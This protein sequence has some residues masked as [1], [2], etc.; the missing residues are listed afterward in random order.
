MERRKSFAEG[1]SKILV[2]HKLIKAEEAVSLQRLFE[3]SPKEYFDDFLLEEGIVDKEDLIKALQEYFKV[4]AVDVVGYFFQPFLVRKFPKDVL[5]RYA[6]IPMDV[7]E[8]MMSVVAS[9]PDDP[10]LLPLI[11]EYVSYD[12]HVN[13][14]LRQDITDAITEFYDKPLTEVQEDVDSRT[15]RLEERGERSQV[16]DEEEEEFP[17]DDE[18]IID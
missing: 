8:N 14:G 2:K 5:H 9:D 15:E 1:L 13:V 12:I 18:D 16:L 4:P 6:F 17:I 10:Q 3:E 7:D 11:A